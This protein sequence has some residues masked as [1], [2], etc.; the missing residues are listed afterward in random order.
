MKSI[1][2]KDSSFVRPPGYSE[3]GNVNVVHVKLG[4][5]ENLLNN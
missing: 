5:T 4:E 1:E 2:R 3:S